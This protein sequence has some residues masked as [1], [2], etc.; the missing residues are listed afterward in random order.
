M[1]NKIAHL[2]VL[3]LLLTI[4][5]LQ[6][7]SAQTAADPQIVAEIA[8]IK[9]ID[10]HAHPLRY[11]AAG[12]KP[13]DEYDALPL[14]GLE[15]FNLP[16]RLSPTNPE[17]IGAWRALFSYGY[18]DMNE[19]HLKELVA[20]K[21]RVMRERGEQYPAWVLDQTGIDTMFA[22][23]VAMGRGFKN[24]PISMGLLC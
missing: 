12:E 3:C 10:N 11:V 6:H 1:K 24:T 17:F 2:V 21:Q 5:P 19:P 23:R 13:D 4:A 14:E 8:K 20:T 22:N 9:A 18:D 16:P 15:P 7:Q